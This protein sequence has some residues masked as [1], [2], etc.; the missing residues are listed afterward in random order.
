[1]LQKW[2]RRARSGS[3]QEGG[4]H[5]ERGAVLV[6][7][8]IVLPILLLLVAGVVEFGVGFHEA[9]SMAAAARAGARSASAM[10]KNQSFAVAAAD[11][12]TQQLGGIT[13]TAPQSIWIFHVATGTNG[14]IG[15]SL[16]TCTECQG[17]PWDPATKRFDTSRSLGNSPWQVAAQNACGA[18]VSD[19]VGVAV[20]LDHKYMFGVFGGT[21]KMQRT[22]VMRLEPFVG[23]TACGAGG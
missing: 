18:S 21:K 8:A 5:Q 12:A 6:E 7:A 14:P 1:M 10:P 3:R 9:S 19:E 4:V 16:V 13:S 22:A 11:A 2:K 20:L 17:F 23:S 15:G